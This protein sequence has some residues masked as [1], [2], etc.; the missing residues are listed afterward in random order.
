MSL[1]FNISVLYVEDEFI[2][3]KDIKRL[4]E[5]K[6]S[7]VY[8]GSDGHE[9]ILLYDKYKIDIIITDIRM[10]NV[11]GIELIKYIRKTNTKI[12]I[13]VTSGFD[14]EFYKLN[15]LNISQYIIKPVDE[16]ALYLELNKAYD[17]IINKLN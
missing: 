16:I 17:L 11:D 12:P 8:A 13:I 10:P 4:L 14:K 9:G 1:K 7:A 3:R 6:V 15:T 5:K 2:I